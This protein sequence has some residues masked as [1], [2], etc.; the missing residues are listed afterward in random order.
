MGSPTS[1][2]LLHV[3]LSALYPALYP[4]AR[5]GGVHDAPVSLSRGA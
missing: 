4:E 5:L 1:E 3:V 2:A